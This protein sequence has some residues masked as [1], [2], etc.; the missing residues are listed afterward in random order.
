VFKKNKIAMFWK[1]DY[2]SVFRKTE[3]EDKEPGPGRRLAQSRAQQIGSLF[4]SELWGA[5]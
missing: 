4:K 5:V 1:L 3:E 2:V